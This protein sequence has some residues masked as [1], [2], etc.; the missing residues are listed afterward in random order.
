MSEM[1][2]RSNASGQGE[3]WIGMSIITATWCVA[4]L[5][6]RCFLFQ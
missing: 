6:V 2:E 5:I 1:T 4:V 3:F